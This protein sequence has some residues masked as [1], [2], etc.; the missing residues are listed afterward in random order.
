MPS[1]QVG[2]IVTNTRQPAWGPGRVFSFAGEC[3]L[4]GFR[5]RP[6]DDRFVRVTPQCLELASVQTDPV[7]EGL[8]VRFDSHCRVISTPR[9]RRRE[10]PDGR[11]PAALTYD[12]AFEH[13]LKVYPGGFADAGYLEAERS[14][15]WAKHLEWNELFPGDTL[16]HLAQTDPGEAARRLLKV[17]QAER[18]PLLTPRFELVALKE[19]LAGDASRR[20]LLALADYLEADANTHGAFD[21]LREALLSMPTDR[22]SSRIGTWPILTVVPFLA[23]PDRHMFLKPTPSC[24]AARQLGYDLL[25]S[26]RLRW[27]TYRRLLDLAAHLFRFLEPK[28]AVDYID[29]QSFLWVLVRGTERTAA[30]PVTP[31]PEAEAEA[32]KA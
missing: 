8:S 22:S 10:D 21:D 20:Y 32:A 6:L 3:V 29:V 9:V 28:G 31:A 14:W 30:V 13:F 25:Y 2:S 4:V 26:S 18:T 1:I 5:D 16:R 23:R 17:V 7:L 15:K 27:D 24:E 11:T 12:Q 19:G